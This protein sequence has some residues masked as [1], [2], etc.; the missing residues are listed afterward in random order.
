MRIYSN[1]PLGVPHT[2]IHTRIFP[3]SETAAYIE[4][5]EVIEGAGDASLVYFMK[6]PINEHL[7]TLL[8]AIEL[9]QKNHQQVT[10]FLPYLPYMRSNSKI[11]LNMLSRMGIAQCITID[12]H[13]DFKHPTL[14]LKNISTAGLFA[15]HIKANHAHKEIVLVAP[16]QGAVKRCEAVYTLLGL[17]SEIIQINK[18]RTNDDCYVQQITGDVNGKTCILIDDIIDTGKTLCNAAEELIKKGATDIFAYCTHGV[19]SEGAIKRVQASPIQ[20]LVVTDTIHQTTK[21]KTLSILN[22]LNSAT[23]PKQANHYSNL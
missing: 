3:D 20:Q 6:S 1:Q 19:F 13:T 5:D 10:V 21:I 22:L 2:L 15:E 9:L 23:S 11:L 4:S 7:I 12:A 16:D 18:I 14:A 8:Q 17:E